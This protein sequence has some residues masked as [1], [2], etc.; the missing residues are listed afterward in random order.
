[1]AIELGSSE[2]GLPEP[3][4]VVGQRMAK[5]ARRQVALLSDNRDRPVREAISSVLD[6]VE[7]LERQ[8]E[9]LH[10]RMVLDFRKLKLE[11]TRVRIGGDGVE[12]VH[13]EAL[14]VG[15][16]IRLHILIPLRGGRNL[17]SVDGIVTSV[18]DDNSTSVTFTS[19]EPETLDLL[20]GFTFEHQRRER[21]R[22]AEA[23]SIS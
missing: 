13:H 17:L 9:L 22:E 21:R 2:E 3:V 20:V 7:T 16:S 1:M 12:F 6:I 5:H 19:D 23:T 10:R 15:D 8:V 4:L 18:D 11:P 14:T